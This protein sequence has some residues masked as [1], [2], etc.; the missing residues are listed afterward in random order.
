MSNKL[1]QAALYGQ[2]FHDYVGTVKAAGSIV[3]METFYLQDPPT[4]KNNTPI[5]L[6]KWTSLGDFG[7]FYESRMSSAT[8]VS[9]E[10]N[11]STE[12][13]TWN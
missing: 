8:P 13:Y 12:K 6:I 5:S 7:M 11:E 9:D 2:K 1:I 10:E 4:G 3:S